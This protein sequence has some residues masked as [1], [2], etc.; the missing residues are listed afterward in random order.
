MKSARRDFLKKAG[1]GLLGL[2]IVGDGLYQTA[3]GQS[4]APSGKKKLGKAKSVIQFW[5]WGGP[6]QLETFD[7][8]PDAGKEYYGPWGTPVKTNVPGIEISQSLPRLAE[9]AD[10]CSYIRSM[11]HGDNGHETAAYMVQTGRISGGNLVY[12]ALGAV[13]S[14]LKGYKYGYDSAIP[15]YIILTNPLGRFSECGFLGTAYKPYATGSDPN[16]RRFLANGFVLDGVDDKR[17]ERRLTLLDSVDLY[18][19]VVKD[20]SLMTDLE[21]ARQGA[22]GVLTGEEVKTF[23]LSTETDE[24]REAYGRTKIGQS[25]LMARRLVEKGVPYIAINYGGGWDTHSRHFEHLTRFQPE[26][27][28]ALS[29]LLKDLRD[30]GLLDTTI[31]WWGGE[32]GRPPKID[33][34]P[35]W[36]GG[37]G[38]YGPCYSNMIAGGG[39]KGGTVVGATDKGEKP[40]K[41]PVKVQDFLGTICM[42]MGLDPDAPMANDKGIEVPIM[43]P[44]SENGLLYEIV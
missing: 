26:W 41:R 7:P 23:D 5:M 43:A 13:I 31:I 10:M 36:F 38:H 24:V 6:S 37:R 16:A 35:P 40:T 3:Q 34:N 32:F 42:L 1:I 20:N 11:T 44:A 8:K 33:Y 25:C 12:P 19:K 14:L 21:Q 9:C 18:G 22:F 17:K 39:I 30:K 4:P 2:P 28:K 27:D 15:P 29:F